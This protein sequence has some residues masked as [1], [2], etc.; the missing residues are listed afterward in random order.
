[1]LYVTT[2]DTEQY[3]T[4]GQVMELPAAPDR[5][6]FVPIRLPELD[7]NQQNELLSMPFS[8]CIAA[9]LNLF[10]P[11]NLTAEQVASAMEGSVDF[12][13]L[14]HKTAMPELWRNKENSVSYGMRRLLELMGCKS[15]EAE[16]WPLVAVGIALLFGM[17][18]Q[19][20]QSGRPDF[21]GNINLA[22]ASGNF[23]MPM[24]AWYAK[25]MGLPIHK[26][27]C[28]CNQNSA[29]WELIHKGEL[30][31]DGQLYHTNTPLL[32]VTI[33]CNLE[34]LLFAC[35]GVSGSL[36]FGSAKVRRKT[37]R[38]EPEQMAVLQEELSVSVIGGSRTRN[39]ISR[40]YKTA[41]YLM[42]PYTALVY[43]GLLDYRA[44]ARESIPAVVLAEEGPVV[45]AAEVL[46]A[47]ELPQEEL[48]KQIERLLE[49]AA[50]KRKA[51]G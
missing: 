51:R 16:Q 5:A 38:L 28:G 14:H 21:Q 10:F 19:L 29:P 7:E 25:K 8:A 3:Y 43:N 12:V 27:I 45:C 49:A 17:F 46:A 13:F 36:T 18:G 24:S 2:R 34:R 30:R 35:F 44:L 47:M 31:L 1:M 9:I 42:S 37:L 48:T 15:R 39:F 33:P 22:V 20:Q 40:I 11:V 32:D 4:A 6:L 26:V 41:Y 23:T 50:L